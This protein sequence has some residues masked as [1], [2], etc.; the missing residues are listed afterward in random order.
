MTFACSM[1]FF[2]EVNSRY[3]TSCGTIESLKNSQNFY[4]CVFISL[5]DVAKYI[6]QLKRDDENLRSVQDV[7][8]R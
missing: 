6:N 8:E 3:I 4:L 7:Q 1:M 5:K 2:D